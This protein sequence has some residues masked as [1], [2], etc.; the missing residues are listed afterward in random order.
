MVNIIDEQLRKSEEGEVQTAAISMQ[1]K[2][3]AAT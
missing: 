3:M 2:E 1:R